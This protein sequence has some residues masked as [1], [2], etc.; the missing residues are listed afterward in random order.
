MRDS[1][2]RA[3]CSVRRAESV[4]DV[5]IAALREL[6][7]EALVVL[8]L[9]RVEARVLEYVDPLVHEERAEVL[10]DRLHPERGILPAR[11]TEVRADPDPRD[12]V[13]EQVFECRQRRTD[14]RVVCDLPALERHVQVGAQEHDLAGD[15]GLA[16]RTRL[17]HAREASV[18]IREPT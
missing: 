2:G 11:P 3:V 15:A 16:D 7:R 12:I 6:P 5:E 18:Q 9:T 10:G 8:G 17:S 4:V 13:L 1:L 14:P